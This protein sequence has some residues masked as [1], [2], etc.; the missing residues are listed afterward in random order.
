MLNKITP[1]NFHKL[2]HKL[3][4]FD[5]KSIQR[6]VALLLIEKA[7]DVPKYSHEYALLCQKLSVELTN[8]E[9]LLVD[10]CND[11]FMNRS[12]AYQMIANA[13]ENQKWILKQ[14]MLAIHKFIGELYML[15]MLCDKWVHACIQHLLDLNRN[16]SIINR[17]NDMEYLSSLLGSCGTKLDTGVSYFFYNADLTNLS[18]ENEFIVNEDFSSFCFLIRTEFLTYSCITFF[19]CL[20]KEMQFRMN[21]YFERIE[22]YASDSRF[23][24]NVQF[25]LRVVI[26]LRKSHWIPPVVLEERLPRSNR[27]DNKEN[28]T[29]KPHKLVERKSGK[30]LNNNNGNK[31]NT[32]HD[33]LQRYS[34]SYATNHSRIRL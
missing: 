4:K 24:L 16:E 34:S 27:N 9:T 14:K 18:I 7:G 33:N 32:H 30:G 5:L 15:D 22:I 20:V 11:L 2:S 29:P 28:I 23:P 19:L 3:L 1:V 17:C 25:M 13:D 10:E 26:N 31:N 12:L 6:D 21:E 8:F